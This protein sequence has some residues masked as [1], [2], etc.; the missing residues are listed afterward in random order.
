VKTAGA[1]AK[2][3]HLA[4]TTSKRESE[5]KVDKLASTYIPPLHHPQHFINA[6]D[7]VSSTAGRREGLRIEFMQTPNKNLFDDVTTLVKQRFEGYGSK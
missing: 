7:T 5:Q 2:G 1:Q 3:A 6:F 4:M